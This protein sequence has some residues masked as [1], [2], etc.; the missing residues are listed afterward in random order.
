MSGKNVYIPDDFIQEYDEVHVISD[1][2]IGG[3]PGFQIFDSGSELG[4]LI[5]HLY[6]DTGKSVLLVING[7]FIDFLAEDNAEYFDPAGAA[8]KLERIFADGAFKPVWG[9]LKEFV[10]AD[11]R[12]LIVNLG[13]HDLELALPWV[14]ECFF[15]EIAG[16]DAVARG[17]IAFVTGGQGVLCRVGKVRVLCAHGNE[18]DDWNLVGQ[19]DLQRMAGDCLKH[20]EA[21]EWTPNAGTKLVIDVMNDIKKDYPFVDLLKPETGGV[22]PILLAAAPEHRAKL[23]K[24]VAVTPKLAKDKLFRFAGLLSGGEDDVAR[25][26]WR[27]VD[28]Q[29]LWRE[30]ESMHEGDIAPGRLDPGGAEARRL[31]LIDAAWSAVRGEDKVESLREALERLIKDRSFDLALKDDTYKYY[32]ENIGPGVDVVIAGHTHL[33]RAVPRSNGGRYYNTGTWARLI[34]LSPQVLNNRKEFQRVYDA[35]TAKKMQA[36]DECE[37][38]VMRRRTVAAV[39]RDG[40]VV[41]SELRNVADRAGPD[42]ASWSEVAGSQA[43][44]T[45]KA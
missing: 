37:G 4:A 9:A 17:R 43:E 39:W 11:K 40:D 23:L 42:E 45:G 29:S 5:S 36:L 44:F 3:R 21:E 10:K 18:S 22:I 38:L 25:D 20:R 41:R 27:E 1:L 35:L 31:G 19:T 32:D 16:D 12:R 14:Q 6:Q 33:A 28:D 7:D 34:H 8:G 15:R 30:I 13:N 2:H 24:F 26:D